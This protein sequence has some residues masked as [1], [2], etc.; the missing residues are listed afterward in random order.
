MPGY[1]SP[2]RRGIAVLIVNG[3]CALSTPIGD[4][5]QA[6]TT[7]GG[8]ETSSTTTPAQTDGTTIAS[9][10]ATGIASG[11]TEM[12]GPGPMRA[13]SLRVAD[14]PEPGTGSASDVGGDTGPVDPDAI[15]VVITTGG[16]TCSDP[17]GQLPCGGAW[18]IG[19]TLALEH[20]V[21]GTY[22]LF[23]ELDGTG[24]A[25]GFE[26]VECSFAGG[27]LDGTA[28]IDVVDAQRVAGRITGASD[29]LGFDPNV[30]FDAPRC[31]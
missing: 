14:L 11:D 4:L 7:G 18:S 1:H 17:F 25:T 8:T 10:S 31:P 16:A 21:P 9:D 27:S 12:V 22:A 15:R 29:L 28:E 24:T 23:E 5:P 30:E 20:Q 6:G 19:F 3:G 13:F 2:V 26:P